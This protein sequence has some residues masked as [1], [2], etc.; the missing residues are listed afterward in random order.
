MNEFLAQVP[1]DL[2]AL[3]LF[4]LVA[5]QRSFTRAAERAGL[6]Q[7][8]VTRQIRMMEEKLGVP[9]LE[10]TTRSVTPTTAG[11]WLLGESQR[12][13]GDVDEVLRR[14]RE[15]FSEARKIVQVGVSRSIGLAYLPGFFH[16]NLRRAP[17]VGYRLRHESG[18][19]IVAALEANALDV[20]VICPPAKLPATL[21]VTHRFDDAFT[22]IASAEVAATFPKRGKPA[23]LATWVEAQNWL[24]LDER[25]QTGRRLRAW[26]AAH[27]CKVEPTLQLDDFDLIINLVTLGMGVS[28]VPIRALALYGRKRTLRRLA[29]PERFVRKLAVVVRA[30]RE[31]PAHVQRFVENVLF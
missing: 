9:L 17:E 18:A 29:W 27:G 4:R 28:F 20:G 15:E 3:S 24:L 8:A 2:Y 21:R 30:K 22:L 11:A 26:M 6:T 5:E 14:M 1:F 12:L 23:S 19:E 25:S 16:A 10:R 31:Q 13:L 7:S